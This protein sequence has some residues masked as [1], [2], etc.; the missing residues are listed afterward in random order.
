MPRVLLRLALSI[1][2]W[3]CHVV[4]A[5]GDYLTVTFGNTDRCERQGTL[6]IDG[7][8]LRFDLSAIPAT[9]HIYR[10]ILQAPSTKRQEGVSVRI[11][12]VGMRQNTPLAYVAPSYQSVNA[13]EA[14]QT[15]V[16]KP[17]TNKGFVAEEDGG[18]DFTQA[19]LAVSYMGTATAPIAPV[20]G[21][22]ALHQSGQT[23][24][25]WRESEDILA[26]DAPT[27]EEF[28]QAVLSA[29]SKR[30]LTYRVYRHTR[31]ITL[32][33]L[34][35]AVLIREVPEVLSAWNLLAVR[36]TEHPNQG[37]PT[38]RTS[39]RHGNLALNHIMTAF[40]ITPGSEPLPRRTGLAVVTAD[41]PGK[42]YYA[43]TTTIN[44]REA[45][46]ALR[47][48]D[49]ATGPV[50]ETPASFPALLYQR[51]NTLPQDK[52]SSG[53]DVK[54]FI[55]WMDPPYDNRQRPIEFF[56]PQWRNQP[57]GTAQQRL[58]VYLIL[59][60]HGS[61][62]TQ[63]EAPVWNAAR[64]YVAGAFTLG[65]AEE[66]AL[67]AGHHE[68]LG[69]WKGYN[70]GVVW[71]YEQRR[72][73]ALTEWALAQHQAFLDPERFYAWGQSAA[74][75][76]RYGERYAVIMSDGHNN[77]KSSREGK[78]HFRRWGPEGKGKNWLGVEHLEYL[79]LATWV[80][81]NPTVELPYWVGFPALGTFPSHTLGD[82]GFK[83]WQEF[84][85]AM[86]ETKRAFAVIWNANGP[87]G[88]MGKVVTEVVPT[89][90]LHQS[91][92]AFTNSA[93]NARILTD[94]PQG[95]VGPHNRKGDPLDMDY[96]MHADKVGGINLY[97]RWDTNAIVDEP[98]RW[99]MTLWLAQDCPEPTTT[100]DVTPRRLQRFAVKPGETVRWTLLDAAGKVIQ[101]GK[102]TGDAWG[103]VTAPQVEL[104]KERRRM[105]MERK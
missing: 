77:Y 92:P 32:D 46:T 85:T 100:L 96:E 36:N 16:A 43:V 47:Q 3:N 68:S 34:G 51:T 28:E 65:F 33:T 11:V 70:D 105:V 27:F 23:F 5:S 40:R 48:G 42:H 2:L 58:P 81:H 95:P 87:V 79:D 63:L 52:P 67:Y 18:V 31:P 21:I 102:T 4:L 14:V 72:V 22:A 29:N 56:H 24:L 84:V 45:V 26:N 69:T 38:K 75:M 99:E 12:P 73:L 104:S 97:P 30:V 76:L 7:K 39:L 88:P 60:A 94:T 78:K 71:N 59:G 35:E 19:V 89:I 6:R 82:F 62:S 17:S 10:A 20:T 91:L 37:T 74:W 13:T 61:S 98:R 86:E 44:G 53:P 83:P 49:N 15:W 93:L 101:S 66:G 9:A 57:P 64:R 8:T 103:L 90:R 25:T 80:R 55:A 50:E 1:V 54:V 41:T